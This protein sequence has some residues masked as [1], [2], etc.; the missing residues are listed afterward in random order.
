MNDFSSFW[1]KTAVFGHVLRDVD[2]T[3]GAPGFDAVT[4]GE[5]EEKYSNFSL[6]MPIFAFPPFPFLTRKSA[7]DCDVVLA[8][9]G[10]LNVVGDIV[11]VSEGLCSMKS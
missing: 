1:F 11:G 5:G 4:D 6:V 8:F 3:E 10:S 7:K 2:V 9:I